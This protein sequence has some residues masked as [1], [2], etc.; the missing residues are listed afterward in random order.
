VGLRDARGAACLVDA[1][2]G[3]LNPGVCRGSGLDLGA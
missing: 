1:Q 3:D 2:G